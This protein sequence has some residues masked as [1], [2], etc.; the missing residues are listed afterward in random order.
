[1]SHET[2]PDGRPWRA[3]LVGLAVT[4]AIGAAIF[5][6]L[7][8]RSGSNRLDETHTSTASS[9]FPTP[10]P[11]GAVAGSATREDLLAKIKLLL[12]QGAGNEARRLLEALARTDPAGALALAAEAARDP[13]E[14][15]LL[16]TTVMKMWAAEA[17][18]KAWAWVTHEGT[19]WDV[20]CR[21]TMISDVLES[22]ASSH[23]SLVGPS[24]SAL[25]RSSDTAIDVGDNVF[26][27]VTS[28]LKA[29]H[30]DLARD[31]FADWS[32]SPR[33]AQ[34][35][36]ATYAAIASELA[37][38]SPRAAAE[39]LQ[40]LPSSP[41]RDAG[42]AALA[43][44]WAQTGPDR[45]MEWSSTLSTASLRE[46]AMRRAFD[47]WVN[48]DVDSAVHWLANHDTDPVADRLMFSWLMGSPVRTDSPDVA[49][50][51]AQLINDPGLRLSAMQ[52]TVVAWARK[53]R[54]AATRF[55]TESTALSAAQKSR[56]L[57]DVRSTQPID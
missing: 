38:S 7:R 55:V 30:A 17:P 43:G 52:Q 25:L 10:H 26:V 33:A 11:A 18:E 37:K 13:L 6:V 19:A 21:A 45:A 51:W 1:M 15:T 44:A 14:K 29:G 46:G 54:N 57:E 39:W 34:I 35:S 56:L 5:A 31:A 20:P 32:R 28:L 48:K 12:A 53:D 42:Y 41:A 3:P 24:V 36:A 23:A 40:K 47:V 49:M 27:A 4:L 9:S 8:G 22:M 50:Q 16:G 2:K